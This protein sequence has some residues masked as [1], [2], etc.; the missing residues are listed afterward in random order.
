MTREPVG[1]DV[2]SPIQAEVFVV[3]LDGDQ[4]RLTGPDGPQAWLLQLGPTEH[5]DRGDE[6]V[7]V[8]VQHPARRHGS[9][10]RDARPS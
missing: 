5:L 1:W 4:L 3:W 2:D 8:D 7:E 9:A 10:P 6:L